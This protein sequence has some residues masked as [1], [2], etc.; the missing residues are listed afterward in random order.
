M[1]KLTVVLFAMLLTACGAEYEKESG[2]IA[3]GGG[4]GNVQ[5]VTLKDGTRCAVLIGY[6][7]G[8]IT[9]DWRQQ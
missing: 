3:G 6:Y 4:G 5:L 2:H 1:R 7:K 8:G 9:C